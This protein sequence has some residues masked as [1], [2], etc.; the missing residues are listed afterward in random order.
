MTSGITANFSASSSVVSGTATGSVKNAMGGVL[1]MPETV[2]V[3][4]RATA[5]AV[6]VPLC[7]LA[8]N[9]FEAGAIAQVGN[10]K[11]NAPTCG[12][13]A[14]T[15]SNTGITQSGG[16][17]Y[18]T[19]ATVRVGG[20]HTGTGYSVPVRDNASKIAD[21]YSS[22]KFPDYNACKGNGQGTMIKKDTTLS[23]G[24]YCGG[25][26]VQSSANVTLLPGVYVMVNGSF[27]VHGNSNVTGDQV[28]IGFTSDGSQPWPAS[29]NLLG[30]STMTVTSPV[31]GTYAN[32][33]FMGDP[34]QV[35]DSNK[36]AWFSVG[37]SN[38][39]GTDVNDSS[40]LTYDGVAYIP[41][42][43]FWVY[44]GATVNANSPSTVLVTDM[45]WPQ[46]SAQL[47]ITTKNTRGLNASPMP[48]VAIG[49]R[50]VN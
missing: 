21:P 1:S 11:V 27:T 15:V 10:S 18:M 9:T 30:N 22:L 26:T 8:L 43:D 20:G 48:N 28:M 5:T 23:P 7:V 25:I 37:G 47:N 4:V 31:S 41:K 39:Q 3:G 34:A 12:I 6:T 46:G 36:K 24:T 50:L 32:I 19:A 2:T 14:N 16:T 40:K 38:G 49:A 42:Q 17:S 44:G 13:Q 33:Q 45:L 35:I 29:L